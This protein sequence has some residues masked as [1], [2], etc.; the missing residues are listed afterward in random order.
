LRV[1]I[2][3]SGVDFPWPVPACILRRGEDECARTRM[4]AET[5]RARAQ[6]MIQGLMRA[7]PKLVLVDPL[8]SLCSPERCPVSRRG[9]VLYSDAH[10]LSLLGAREL[11][12]ALSRAI[13]GS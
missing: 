3:E 11:V 7:H 5:R 4:Q 8:N 9:I 6:A 13:G 2:V 10:H 12:P 1:V